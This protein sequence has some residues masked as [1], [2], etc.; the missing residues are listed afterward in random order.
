M[1]HSP[2]NAVFNPWVRKIPWRKKW[3]PTPVFLP[4]KSHGQRSQVSYSS[5]SHRR[6]GYILATKQKRIRWNIMANDE[7]TYSKANTHTHRIQST[8]PLVPHYG[9]NVAA[10]G[11]SEIVGKA[12]F[13]FM[14]M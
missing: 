9:L 8:G 1:A 3:Q 2:A 4:G 6:V 10:A 11:N 14:H 7:A 5:W 12:N 13:R